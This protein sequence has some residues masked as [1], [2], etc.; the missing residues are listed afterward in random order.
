MQRH[1]AHMHMYVC[2]PTHTHTHTLT[3]THAQRNMCL[4]NYNYF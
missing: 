4:G 3:P 1:P 2:S